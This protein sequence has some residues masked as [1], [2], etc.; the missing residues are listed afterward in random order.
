M[1]GQPHN[2]TAEDLLHIH[3][4]ITR[5][6]REMIATGRFAK[7]DEMAKCLVHLY[8]RVQVMQLRGGAD[9][10]RPNV[11]LSLTFVGAISASH[12]RRGAPP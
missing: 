10:S 8:A 1:S 4:S 7:A 11:N 3:L 9:K 5:A 6:Y 12:P 2:L